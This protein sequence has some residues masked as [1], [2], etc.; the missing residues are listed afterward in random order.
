M[1]SR[2]ATLAAIKALEDLGIPYMLVDSLSSNAYGIARSTKDADFVIEL[3][4]VTITDL[5]RRL[6]P[7]FKLGAQISFETVTG[8]MYHV[9][10]LADT[11]FTIEFFRLS[12]DPHDQE[13]FAAASEFNYR[14]VKLSFQPLRT[15]SL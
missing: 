9:V 2:E 7:G 12:N 11:S 10:Q 6:G 4:T 15:S 1:T 8:T 3:S 5:V 14:R 13:R